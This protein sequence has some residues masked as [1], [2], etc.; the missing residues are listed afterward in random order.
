MFTEIAERKI[1]IFASDLHVS[2]QIMNKLIIFKTCHDIFGSRCERISCHMGIHIA[3][4]EAGIDLMPHF[5]RQRTGY[6][7]IVQSRERFLRIILQFGE[8]NRMIRMNVF[9]IH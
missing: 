9:F 8:R 2:G 5:H 3:D 7:L 4:H 1:R 6:K